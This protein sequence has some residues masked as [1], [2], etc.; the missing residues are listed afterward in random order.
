MS[1]NSLA[2]LKA[3]N[4]SLN[5]LQKLQKDG[6]IQLSIDVY[7][8]PSRQKEKITLELGVS[9][10]LDVLLSALIKAAKDRQDYWLKASQRDL[11]DL[12]AGLAEFQK[13]Q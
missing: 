7:T 12:Q 4:V 2:C 6:V 3:S 11:D 13:G 8:C 5:K 10:D 9:T 1:L